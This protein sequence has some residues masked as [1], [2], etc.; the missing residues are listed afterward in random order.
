MKKIL[1]AL[2]VIACM[3]AVVSCGN[4]VPVE[5]F[6]DAA[7]AT[8][9]S[10]IQLYVKQ[11]TAD[12]EL[13]LSVV[14]NY[15]EDGSSTIVGTRDVINSDTSGASD[16]LVT[17]VPVNVTCDANGN[18]SDGGAFS[19]SSAVSSGVKFNFSKNKMAA[20]VS[21]DGTVLNANIEAANT[22]SVLGVK[23]DADV[24][25]TVTVNDGKIASFTMEYTSQQGPVYVNCIYN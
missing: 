15:A 7:A 8:S 25:L 2:L 23:I 4:T 6:N 11:T 21:A 3:L 19:G 10:K 12:A 17:T 1:C 14:I 22:E 20:T 9:P 13:E 24:T 18:Y 16:E 5:T